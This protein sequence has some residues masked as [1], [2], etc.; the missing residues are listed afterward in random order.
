MNIFDWA[1]LKLSR[2][3]L[4]QVVQVK[5]KIIFHVVLEKAEDGWIVG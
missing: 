4:I 2:L 5:K 1:I 3:S